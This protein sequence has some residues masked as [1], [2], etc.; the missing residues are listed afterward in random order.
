M[1]PVSREYGVDHIQVFRNSVTK[2]KFKI[3]LEDLRSKHPFEDILLVMDNL[4]FHKSIDV[5]ERMDAL[6]FLYTYTPV[7]SPR[8]NGI[9]EVFSIA[10]RAIKKERL[11]RLLNGFEENMLQIIHNAFY[12]INI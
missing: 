11:T 5:K 12:N 3:F 6:G 9:E 1:V 7:Y 4:S 10:K 2:V 8:H